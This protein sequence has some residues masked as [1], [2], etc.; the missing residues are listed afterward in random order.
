[1]NAGV[2]K[3]LSDFF[4]GELPKDFPPCPGGQ[5]ESESITRPWSRT[6]AYAIAASLLLVLGIKIIP[7]GLSKS[8]ATDDPWGR[9]TAEGKVMK[10]FESDGRK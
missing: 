7:G 10:V 4:H 6:I 5:A 8:P 1:M 2:D 3:Q 9:A